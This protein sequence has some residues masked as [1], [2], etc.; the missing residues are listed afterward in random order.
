MEEKP[1]ISD[2][3]IRVNGIVNV[4]E[5]EHWEKFWD[6]FIIWLENRGGGFF[7]VTEPINKD[8]EGES[9]IE[10]ILEDSGIRFDE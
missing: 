6:D 1:L 10:K 7:G 4:P 2:N 9:V 8:E 3:A 5:G